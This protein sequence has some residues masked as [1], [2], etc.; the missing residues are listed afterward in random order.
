MRANRTGG[1]SCRRSYGSGCRVL[2]R[3]GDCDGRVLVPVRRRPAADDRRR[4]RGRRGRP[5][6]CAALERVR[7]GAR[8]RRSRAPTSPPR[9]SPRSPAA[10]ALSFDGQG[11]V[12]PDRT[13]PL[14][15]DADYDP[16]GA[17]PRVGAQAR[18]GGGAVL[19]GE[20]DEEALRSLGVPEVV[21]TLG[22]RG[23]ARARRRAARARRGA[24]RRRRGRPDRRR[25]RVRRRLPRLARGRATRRR[26]RHGARPRVVAGLLDGRLR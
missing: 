10:G 7:L 23:V 3:G 1:C 18:R 22:S 9:R 5:P 20:P 26:P 14:E 11:L 24:A 21:V 6:T 15:L 8:R 17:A 4:T 2:W 16:R 12:R 19:V 25:R 13:G